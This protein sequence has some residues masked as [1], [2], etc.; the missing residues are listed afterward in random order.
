MADEHTTLAVTFA[1]AGKSDAN[2][3]LTVSAVALKPSTRHATSVAAGKSDAKR[4]L[5]L[6]ANVRL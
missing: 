3:L 4:G 5:T 1:A 2:Q 6:D